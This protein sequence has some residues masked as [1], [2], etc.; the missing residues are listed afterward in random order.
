MQR[1]NVNDRVLAASVKAQSAAE[2]GQRRAVNG[3]QRRVD[4]F[5]G[6]TGAETA[7]YA[8]LG[9]VG[10]TAC[11]VLVKVLKDSGFF[12]N[13]FEDLGSILDLGSWLP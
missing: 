11:G 7:E 9:G 13:I 12:S 6:E 5:E 10:A 3:L 4:R 2:H 1:I 8:M